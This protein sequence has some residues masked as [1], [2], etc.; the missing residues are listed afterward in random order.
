MNGVESGDAIS[1]NSHENLTYEIGQTGH[2]ITWVI[3]DTTVSTPGYTIYQNG[4]VNAT[5]T[6]TS[7]TPIIMDLDPLGVG[8]YNFTIIA[9]DG[10]SGIAED[11]V[12]I[13][14][15][16]KITTHPTEVNPTD[17]KVDPFA[18]HPLRNVPGYPLLVFSSVILVSI[19]GFLWN[20]RRKK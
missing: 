16:S 18:D 3:T 4:T 17:S 19:V 12:I 9:N 10:F 7:G 20:I 15:E 8:V 2:N 5:G 11:E 6:W 14:I 13:T 1:I